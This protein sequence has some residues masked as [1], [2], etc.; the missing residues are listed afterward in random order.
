MNV[1]EPPGVLRRKPARGNDLDLALAKISF[2]GPLLKE[3]GTYSLF[4]VPSSP[5]ARASP[6]LA[7]ACGRKDG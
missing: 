3:S 5:V 1:H 7:H 4:A 2:N 6:M